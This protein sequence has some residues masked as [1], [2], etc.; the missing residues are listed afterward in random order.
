M[1]VLEQPDAAT[2]AHLA[3]TQPSGSAVDDSDVAVLSSV[4]HKRQTVSGLG[5]FTA[6]E[7]GRV[8]VRFNDRTLVSI[9]RWHR[10]AEVLHRDGKRAIVSVRL[11]SLLAD[12]PAPS[13]IALC[14]CIMPVAQ[15]RACI[16]RR[17]HIL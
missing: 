6:F 3:A 7:D 17:S 13:N 9:D 10:Q 4:V 1:A 14:G 5:V 11:T 16:V 2:A 15:E 8:R 12:P